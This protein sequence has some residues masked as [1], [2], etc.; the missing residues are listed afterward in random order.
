MMMKLLE[1]MRREC[2][3]TMNPSDSSYDSD[4]VA[5]SDSSASASASETGT[6]D[7]GRGRGRGGGAD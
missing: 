1:L 4:L 7:A 5:S 3:L 6:G 2:I